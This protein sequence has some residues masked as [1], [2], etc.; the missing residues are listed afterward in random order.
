MTADKVSVR[1][2][3]GEVLFWQMRYPVVDGRFFRFIERLGITREEYN[4]IR[5][6]RDALIAVLN[7]RINELTDR[8]DWERLIELGDYWDLGPATVNEWAKHAATRAMNQG[9]FAK[10]AE[11]ASRHDFDHE[12]RA[13][14]FSAYEADC[15]RNGRSI[16]FSLFARDLPSLPPGWRPKS[17][18][19]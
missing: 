14:M 9:E 7:L 13:R 6:D 5:E 11:F 10:A 15:L 1:G 18:N 19:Y 12:L 17:H 4:Q 3:A 2:F 8:E 16:E